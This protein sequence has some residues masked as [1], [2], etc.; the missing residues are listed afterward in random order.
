LHHITLGEA[1]SLF[2]LPSAAPSARAPLTSTMVVADSIGGAINR[3][4]DSRG[5]TA[6]LRC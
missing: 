1:S 4:S 5:L 2:L 6:H 3:R